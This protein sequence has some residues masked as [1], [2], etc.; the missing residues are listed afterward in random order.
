[1]AQAPTM[2]P[3]DETDDEFD[4]GQMPDEGGPNTEA[5]AEPDTVILA[6]VGRR[7]KPDGGYELVVFDGPGPDA[8]SDD[9]EADMAGKPLL[10]GEMDDAE[11]GP[12]AQAGRPA[13]NRSQALAFVEQLIRN[14]PALAEQD[15]EKQ[16]RDNVMAGFNGY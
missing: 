10:G 9:A 12:V 5:T 4:D 8:D 16:H 2:M 14:D 7:K 13:E 15:P 3:T 1:M 11:P 6:S